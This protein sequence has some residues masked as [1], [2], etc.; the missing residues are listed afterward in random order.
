M[1]QKEQ[2]CP[3]EAR[4][5]KTERR[6]VHAMQL[7]R[8]ILGQLARQILQLD[9]QDIDDLEQAIRRHAL[10]QSRGQIPVGTGDLQGAP[11][12]VVAV[13]VE[14]RIAQAFVVAPENQV[15]QPLS[16]EDGYRMRM[17]V[18]PPVV[19][20]QVVRYVGESLRNGSARGGNC[21]IVAVFHFADAI[22]CFRY[23]S[24][25]SDQ[26]GRTPMR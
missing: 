15:N 5:G 25:K 18:G 16:L 6:G 21:L 7:D 9:R 20:L 19:R 24:G 8:Q 26:A 13:I 1:E 11:H 10:R 3:V 4:V 22:K 17:D 14:H 23:K 2:Q 12:Q